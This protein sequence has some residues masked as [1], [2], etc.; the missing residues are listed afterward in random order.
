MPSVV[1]IYIYRSNAVG[2]ELPI[3]RYDYLFGCETIPLQGYF[4][5][6]SHF[7][8]SFLRHNCFAGIAGFQR[9][10][11]QREVSIP[12]NRIQT[13]DSFSKRLAVFSLIV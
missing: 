8:E 9:K 10:E 13:A 7:C 11:C 3:I 12:Q 6:A 1:T 5:A 2:V 4:F